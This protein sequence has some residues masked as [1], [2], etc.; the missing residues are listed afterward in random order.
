MSIPSNCAISYGTERYVTFYCTSKEQLVYDI[1]RMSI[2]H[3]DSTLITS[4]L[5]NSGAMS[6]YLS[7]IYDNNDECT[8]IDYDLTLLSPNEFCDY[9]LITYEPIKATFVAPESVELTDVTFPCYIT[10]CSIDSFDRTGGVSGDIFIITPDNKSTNITIDGVADDIT[11][12]LNNQTNSTS[13]QANQGKIANLYKSGK[14]TREE[15]EKLMG[16]T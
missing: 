5:L 14:I 16:W 10:Y 9:G 4:D 6:P 2:T 7:V 12:F 3:I 8:T 1:Q 13:Y 11:D 15:A